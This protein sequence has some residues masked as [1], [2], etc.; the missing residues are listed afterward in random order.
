MMFFIR[1]LLISFVIVLACL[2]MVYGFLVWQVQ[3][4]PPID[5][6]DLL[7]EQAD[8]M[9]ETRSENMEDRDIIEGNIFTTTGARVPRKEWLS[10]VNKLEPRYVH[11]D[12]PTAADPPDRLV[13]VLRPRDYYKAY[14]VLLESSDV[15]GNVPEDWRETKHPMIYKLGKR[16][17]Y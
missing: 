16:V 13:I 17:G 8:K 10:E 11:F 12:S 5:N 15:H 1:R 4:F 2:A 9:L 3:R 14:I 7:V 6:P